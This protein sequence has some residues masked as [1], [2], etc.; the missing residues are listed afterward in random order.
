M[1]K[2]KT[3]STITSKFQ[4][5][6]PK[7]IR[8]LLDVKEGDKLIFTVN[9]R[10]EITIKKAAIVAFDELSRLLSKEAAKQGYTEEQLEEDLKRAKEEAWKSFYGK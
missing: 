3:T 6:I 4:V 10:G 1:E 9:D 8:E 2:V 5:T 7:R